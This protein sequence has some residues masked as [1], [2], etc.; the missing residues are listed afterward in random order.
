MHKCKSEPY[1]FGRLVPTHHDVLQLVTIEIFLLEHLAHAAQ[2]VRWR[3]AE[4]KS[5]YFVACC[6]VPKA[7]LAGNV[8]YRVV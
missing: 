3:D 7:T 1:R 8:V 6:S 5:E 2:I 4:G